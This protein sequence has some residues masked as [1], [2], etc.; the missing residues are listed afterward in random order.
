[1]SRQIPRV[2]AR[3]AAIENLVR[4]KSLRFISVVIFVISAASVMAL[5][6]VSLIWLAMRAIF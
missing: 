3:K 5:W 4:T 1:M 2:H 6:I